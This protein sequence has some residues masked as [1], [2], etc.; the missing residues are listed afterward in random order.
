MDWDYGLSEKQVLQSRQKNGGNSLPQPK[1]VTF[2]HK[3]LQSFGDP[4]IRILLIALG[5]NLLLLFRGSAWFETIGIAFSVVLSTLVSTISEYGSE[6]AFENLQKQASLGKVRVKRNGTTIV[7]TTQELVVGD[8]VLLSAG[9][10]VPADGLLVDGAL[11]VDQAA[12]T[13]E[14]KEVKKYVLPKPYSS[15]LSQKNC[16]FCGS[17]ICSGEGIM[18]VCQVGASTHIGQ[19]ADSLGE[20]TGGS[21]L[22]DK[23][24]VLALKIGRVGYLAAFMVVFADLFHSI[25]MDN[26]F[27][28][29]FIMATIQDTPVLLSHIL[30]ALTLGVTLVVVA[31][32]EGLPM[33]ITV[34]LSRNMLKMQ[35]DHVMVRRLVGIETAG[36]M[37]ILFTDKT[38][39]LTTGKTQVDFVMDG[40]GKAYKTIESM[41]QNQG[42]YDSL[43]KCALFGSVK[44]SA[45]KIIG[46][47]ST[48]RAL[49]NFAQSQRGKYTNVSA[50]ENMPFDSKYKYSYVKIGG[51]YFIKGAPEYLL[52]HCKISLGGAPFQ[53]QSVFSTLQEKADEGFRMI[54][55]AKANQKPTENAFPPL[56]FVA[57]VG[58]SDSLRVGVN[59]AVK[60]VQGAGVQVVMIT[61]DSLGTAVAIG[62]RCGLT[63]GVC[64]YPQAIDAAKLRQMSDEQVGDI[65]PKLRIVAR[66][67]P[68]DK[69]RLVQISQNKNLCV[70][71]TGDGLNDAPALKKADVGFAMGSGSEVSKQA[72][73]II[74]LDD[75]FVSIGKAI[76]YGRTITRSIKKFITFQLCMNLTAA[77][78]SMIGPFIGIEAPITVVQ[79]LWINLLMDTFAGLAFAGEPPLSRYMNEPPIRRDAPVLDNKMVKTVLCQGGYMLIL[80]LCF[81]GLPF[82][83]AP[84]GQNTTPHLTAFFALF[85]YCGIFS[86]FSARTTRLNPL[87]SIYKNKS[88]LLIMGF[89]ALFQ[90]VFIFVGG[91]LFRTGGLTLAGLVQTM[92]L[93]FSVI[94]ADMLRKLFFRCVKS[95]SRPQHAKPPKNIR[96]KYRPQ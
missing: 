96:P 8:V 26:A 31:V 64:D 54:C 4:I 77:G 95:Q 14:S 90:A 41:R 42:L 7:V 51:D 49:A 66:A 88:F 19:M 75:N 55:V 57:L 6:A 30:H 91:S 78:V 79:M 48:D 83:Y 18:Q 58:L 37:N 3:Y 33:M 46:G 53:K 81:L 65:L 70:G 25:V 68:Q 73:D 15:S 76:L 63:N 36:G 86:S 28:P 12:L 92:L 5:L 16:L 60:Q 43:C 29:L 27:S 38:G 62:K 85:V 93:A 17:V 1:K 39:T 11:D 72:G 56:S 47:N 10:Y 21:P 22:R 84:F 44:F 9:E 23:L 80:S 52:P 2:F 89:V 74:L 24:E 71:M 94:P 61:G 69:L 13:G 34:V 87:G 59:A 35:K 40:S 45:N 50:T 20:A 32:P 82:F 67:V